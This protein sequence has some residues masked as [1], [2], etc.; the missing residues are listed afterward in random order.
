MLALK[1]K[2]YGHTRNEIQSFSLAL[3]G[4]LS[5][6]PFNTRSENRASRET[7]ISK[8]IHFIIYGGRHVLRMEERTFSL[9]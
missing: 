2:L 4:D 9:S 7:L 6:F 3:L 1:I 5:Y 8:P